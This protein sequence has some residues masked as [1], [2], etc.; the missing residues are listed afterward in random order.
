MAAGRKE[1][2]PPWPGA[3]PSCSGGAFHPWVSVLEK[4][5]RPLL[6]LPTRVDVRISKDTSAV[7]FPSRPGVG[8]GRPEGGPRVPRVVV[9]GSCTPHLVRPTAAQWIL[10]DAYTK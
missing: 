10:A 7:T 6:P 1:S 5:K 4:P 2:C 8:V 3:W 9:L